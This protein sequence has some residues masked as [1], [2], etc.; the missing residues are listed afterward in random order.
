MAIGLIFPGVF[1]LILTLRSIKALNRQ[2]ANLPTHQ[3]TMNWDLYETDFAI[4]IYRDGVLTR[5]IRRQ[6]SDVAA[7]WQDGDLYTLLVE[8]SLYILPVASMPKNSH[9]L[10]AI[11]RKLT[12]HSP[13]PSWKNGAPPSFG[14]P[15]LPCLFP[16][17]LPCWCRIIT[18]ATTPNICT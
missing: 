12:V 15:S 18:A 6:Y 2:K 11:T 16:P 14:S 8:N 5:Y 13:K 7:A 4:S 9:L 17:G 1:M 10:A 3:V